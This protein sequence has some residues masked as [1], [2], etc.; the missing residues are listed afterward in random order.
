MLWLR[1]LLVVLVL[2]TGGAARL[3]MAAEV[4]AQAEASKEPPAPLASL[5]LELGEWSGSEAQLDPLIARAT[6]ATDSLLRRYQDKRTGTTID[7]ILLYGPPGALFIHAPEVC[8][9][10]SGYLSVGNPAGSDRSVKA[11]GLEAPVPVRALAYAKGQ[12]GSAE[13][14]EVY[15]SWRLGDQWTLSPG[16]FKRIERVAGMYKVQISR[17]VRP[18]ELVGSQ[19]RPDEGGNPCEDF[20]KEL[21]PKLLETQTR[22]PA[23]GPSPAPA[24]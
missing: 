8:Y 19:L 20:L 16:L 18:G 5:P 4:R 10:A 9:P 14:L 2:L 3:R 23:L 22:P 6:G 1:S 12:G 17:P 11:L 21:L 15:Y 13:L 7:V 24:R